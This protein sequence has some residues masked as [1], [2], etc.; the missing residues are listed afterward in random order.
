METAAF[1]AKLIAALNEKVPSHPAERCLKVRQDASAAEEN[2]TSRA[3][4]RG[5]LVAMTMGQEAKKPG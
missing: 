2:L 4:G 5:A 3:P 1:T